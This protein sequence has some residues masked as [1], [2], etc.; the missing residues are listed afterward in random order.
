MNTL[1]KAI[2]NSEN[3]LAAVTKCSRDTALRDI[4]GL[5]NK[6]LLKKMNYVPKAVV[7]K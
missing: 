5:I 2:L 7:E 3:T 4:Q 6:G 1:L